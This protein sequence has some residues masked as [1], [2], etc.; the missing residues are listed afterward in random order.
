MKTFLKKYCSA[1]LLIVTS[2]VLQAMPSYDDVLVV[3]NDKSPASLEIGEY[4]KNARKIPDI[5]VV[6]VSMTD[7]QSAGSEAGQASADEKKALVDAIRNHMTTN[8]LTD[9]INYVVLTRGIPM[10]AVS[11]E[12]P[13]STGS[14][15]HLTDVYVMFR[16]SESAADSSIPDI[17]VK[18][19]YFYYYNTDIL[20]KKFSSK[21]FGYYI[22]SRLDGPGVNNIK[23]VIDDTGFPAYGSYKKN[24]GKAKFLT[25]HQAISPLVKNE[26]K[27][28]NIEL[29]QV[30]ANATTK[31]LTATMDTVAKDVM[32]AY[33]NNVNF[34]YAA[35]PA[36]NN[37][38]GDSDMVGQYPFI[39]RGAT[40]LPGSFATCFRSHPSRQ[41]NRDLGGLLAI[42]AD[43]A[44][45]T[46]YQKSYDGSDIKFRHQT[47][48]AYD[49]VNNQIWC[50]TG[51]PAINV[52]MGFDSRGTD[53]F[54]REHMRNEGGGVAIYDAANGNIL[55]W[56]NANDAGSSLKNNR[57]V[58]MAYDQASKLMWVMHYKGVQY[59]DLVGKAWHDVPALQ[60]DFA[61]GCSIYVD[62]Y[63][64]DKVYFSFY[65]SDNGGYAKVS[66]Q[67][68]G[69]ISSIY[70][71]SKSAKTVKTYAIDTDS[72]VAGMAP[73]MLKTSAST[74]WVAKGRYVKG[75]KQIALIRYDLANKAI[76]E[77][78]L[79][80]DLIPE[81]S[82]PPADLKTVLLKSPY[83]MVAGPN[84]T[85]LV[86]VGCGITY[87]AARTSDDGKTTY[88]GEAKNYVIIV[89][90]KT[91][92]AST[93]EVISD[94][95]INATHGSIAPE[96]YAR[97][98]I[99]DPQNNSK[100]YM[101]LSWPYASPGT[102][103]K[104]T[105]GGRTWSKLSTS[106][107]FLN[108]YDLAI[109][110]KTVYAV[111][112]Y[113]SAQNLLCDFEAF[114]LNAFGGGIV[115]DT[116]LYNPS[117]VSAPLY[118]RGANDIYAADSKSN[119]SIS[120]Y[121]DTSGKFYEG[122]DSLKTYKTG[123]LVANGTWVYASK[124]DNNVGNPLASVWKAVDISNINDYSA[125]A[126]YKAYDFIRYKEKVYFS[127]S[128]NNT[129]APD[130][131]YGVY[132]WKETDISNI[133]EY[134]SSTQY[135]ANSIVLYNAVYY[136][137]QQS[138]KGATPGVEY[139]QQTSTAATTSSDP[140]SQTEP[141]MFLYTDGFSIAEVRFATQSQY[142]Q[143][144]AG[145]YTGH[146][147]MF[148]P[149][150]A[151]FAPRVDEEN[152]N[153]MIPDK[154]TIEIPLRSPGL[155]LSDDGFIPETISNSTVTVKN[156][157]NQP[158]TAAIEY[159]ASGN[160]IVLTGDFSGSFY[161]VTLKCGNN[162]IK[163]IKGASLTNTRETEFKD[164]ITYTFG[165]STEI[166]IPPDDV[167]GPVK[168]P[169]S[170]SKCD[171]IVSRV[172]W[173][174][175]P[176]IGQPLT[177]NFEIKNLGTAKT[178]A[179]AG[180]QKAK[181]YVNNVLVDVKSYDDIAAKGK[182]TLTA[183]VPGAKIEGG[184]QSKVMVCVD[185]TDKV[186]EIRETNNTNS[187]SFMIETRPDLIVKE[188]KLSPK[189][190][191]K[192]PLTI[193]F[194]IGNIGVSA[195]AAGA[196]GQ[197]ATVFVDRKEVGTVT[198][199]D[200]PKGGS[201]AAQLVLPDGIATGGVHKIKVYADTNKAVDEISKLNNALE[202]SF[203]IAK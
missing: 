198:Y 100:M 18:N 55:S 75:S 29:V 58:K 166:Y 173:T 16:L 176:V 161:R 192:A 25:L 143:I 8:K 10:Y 125:T 153:P 93:A 106:S 162:G 80:G 62:P 193:N 30:P 152:M 73:Q 179:G 66:S 56:I 81:I 124:Q 133:G 195:T 117:P 182:I 158:V 154:K 33:F 105:D 67:I 149:K 7:K 196:G 20:N 50:G 109:N 21:M 159:V 94:P 97:S 138:T 52:N 160:K 101:T 164:E 77:K 46:D 32:F 119:G 194:K 39:Y 113:Q 54:F 131:G 201:I 96:Y 110:N 167:T 135:A 144:G 24:G 199:D 107:K 168:M 150:C 90:E 134:S 27:K 136:M 36:D 72:A 69:A 65:Y 123:D 60:N 74:L 83:A 45:I 34:G 181:V 1:A 186:A 28:R 187:A 146:F 180:I 148:E 127:I 115:H 163:N 191:A 112:G 140:Y 129:Y 86:S 12:M 11:P 23:K 51:E 185:A 202:K 128:G 42:N 35:L 41:M 76:V 2:F 171:L 200:V 151:P 157:L 13:T 70:E 82:S 88:V 114:G 132:F 26:I 184:K 118:A 120:C 63:D 147:L 104:S 203:P 9:K 111:R 141:M 59:Y 174:G 92:S 165:I 116:M 137:T 130:E 169:A 155:A 183:T 190:K 95:A 79:L 139:W 85:I 19:K 91:G 78:I 126:T 175:K 102:L 37:F 40:F 87:T 14:V 84:N 47:C 177:V 103:A 3:V 156:E 188:I 49:P 189:P 122:W 145:G 15:F 170:S 43:T 44:V 48:V 57:V 22:V 68:S 108:S 17:F 64:S 142:P 4:F 121:V 5:N 61:A 98:L 31:Q 6:H 71:Y 38:Y 172:W 197:V 89:T 178:N 99:A 53:E